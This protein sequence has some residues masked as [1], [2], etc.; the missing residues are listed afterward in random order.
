MR[1][2]RQ[3]D[4]LLRKI[5]QIPEY[6]KPV[7]ESGDITNTVFVEQD[8]VIIHGESGHKHVLSGVKTY[9]SDW[10]HGRAI[11]IVVD[12]PVTLKHDEHPD[13]EI[14]RGVYVVTRIRDYALN[15]VID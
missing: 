6:A 14:P 5:D 11:Y 13:I 10:D 7:K 1:I 9:T 8:A 4:V 12:K 15:Q 3:G 2:I